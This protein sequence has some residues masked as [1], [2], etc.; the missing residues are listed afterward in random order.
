[1]KRKI[2]F[3]AKSIDNSEWAFGVIHNDGSASFLH[4]CFKNSY[5]MCIHY[6]EQTAHLLGT[7]DNWEENK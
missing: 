2:K 7:T 1:M 6:N 3:R 5:T 4:V